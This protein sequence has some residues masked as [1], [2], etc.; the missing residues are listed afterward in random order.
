MRD[1][2]ALVGIA[3]GATS[4]LPDETPAP[5]VVHIIHRLQI[6]GMENGLVNLINR[7]SEARYR[8]AIVCLTESTDFCERIARKD[9]EIVALNKRD[10]KDPAI[11]RRVWRLLR[12]LQPAIVHTRNLPTIDMASTAVV[13]GVRHR[14]HGEH[15]RDSFEVDGGNRKYNLMRRVISP[16]VSRYVTVSR[17]LEVWLRDVV[18][19]PARKVRQI[20]NGV[21]CAMFQPAQNG[22]TPLPIDGFADDDSIIFGTVGRMQSVKDQPTLARAF[23]RLHGLAGDDGHRMRLV[24][25][26]DGPLRAEAQAILDQAGL[27]RQAWVPGARNDVRDLLKALDV[28]VLPSIAEGIC[29]TILEAM[30]SG[31]PVIATAVGGNPELVFEGETGALVP[32][33]E[34]EAM[35]ASMLGYV[36]NPALARQHGATG[37]R[38]AETAFDLNVMVENYL[39]LYDE[40][41]HA[42]R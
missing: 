9:V 12:R 14:V 3:N 21:D 25:I 23:V 28:F 15:G 42:K 26:G 18:G 31:L 11:Y 24:L 1:D 8:H 33:S 4:M 32:P 38:R 19:A 17:D 10:G 16:A 35:A 40:L 2:A 37:R 22:R 34:P 39:G 29:N 27:G 20:Y 6:G 36:T 41:L 30:A 5:L 13:A 7:T